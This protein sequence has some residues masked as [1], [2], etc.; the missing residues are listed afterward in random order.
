MKTLDILIFC[1][2]FSYN[3][4][5]FIKAMISF[6]DSSTRNQKRERDTFEAFRHVIEAFNKQCAKNIV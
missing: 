3:P 1:S 5:V 4:Y 6:D 2:L